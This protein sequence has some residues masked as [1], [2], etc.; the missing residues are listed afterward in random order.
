[1]WYIFL[2]NLPKFCEKRFIN[3][4]LFTNY[5]FFSGTRVTT[6]I[7]FCSWKVTKTSSKTIFSIFLFYF[8]ISYIFLRNI[9]KFQVKIFINNCLITIYWFWTRCFWPGPG[10]QLLL[11][12]HDWYHQE[13]NP[14]CLRDSP[15][16]NQ[17]SR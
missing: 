1:M 15:C 11:A 5:R 7:S 14:G 3:N 8:T 4:N 13:S 12:I 16:T 2:R 10:L 17:G 9:T 6:F